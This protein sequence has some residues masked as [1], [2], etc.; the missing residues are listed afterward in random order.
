MIFEFG[1]VV[2]VPFPFTDQTASKQ[3]PAVVVSSRAYAVE[4]P[5]V[6]MMPV[7]SQLRPMLAVGEVWLRH[8]QAAG[9]LK[10]SAVKPVIA[11]LESRLIIRLLGVLSAGDQD[12][13]RS[14]A[15]RI[16]G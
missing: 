1:Q 15:R 14:A 4:R 12:S 6:V 7:T 11:T 3:R 13:L 5:D 8:W 10:P 2:L 9:L 16:I